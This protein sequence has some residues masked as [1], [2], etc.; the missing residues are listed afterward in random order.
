MW[1]HSGS[2]AGGGVAG[3]GRNRAAGRFAGEHCFDEGLAFFFIKLPPGRTQEA[4]PVDPEVVWGSWTYHC[5][6]QGPRCSSWLP[7]RLGLTHTEEAV[8]VV[9]L[10]LPEFVAISVPYH[11]EMGMISHLEIHLRNHINT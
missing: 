3:A 10:G 5:H 4:R 7:R 11:C 8:P 1:P 9:L 6:L 2:G